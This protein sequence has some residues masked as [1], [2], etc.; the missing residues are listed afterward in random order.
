MKK[1]Y[2]KMLWRVSRWWYRVKLW[3][4]WW[5]CEQCEKMHSPFTA[6]YEFDENQEYVCHR[7]E[8]ERGK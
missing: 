8:V 4:G 3:F 7:G 1:L 2:R 6:R 5:H